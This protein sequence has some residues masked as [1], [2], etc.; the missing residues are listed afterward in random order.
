M[1]SEIVLLTGTFAFLL[2]TTYIWPE[3]VN[4]TQPRRSS[5]TAALQC[6]GIAV[7]LTA[8]LLFVWS[9]CSLGRSWSPIVEA[10]AQ[11][12]LVT[13]GLYRFARHPMYTSFLLYAVAA[14]EH[15]APC[16][17]LFLLVCVFTP[18][19]AGCVPA[20]CSLN[21]LTAA[22]II[23]ISV[24]ASSRFREEE[25]LMM[26]LYGEQYAAYLREGPGLFAPRGLCGGCE[27]C[28]YA[29]NPL[30]AEAAAPL[31]T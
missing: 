23:V 1:R 17:R 10:D 7:S 18:D 5:L 29:R 9:H 21:L 3:V 8:T 22:S 28:C 27:A 26:K 12:E 19:G 14:G 11:H 31:L 24:W 4:Y 20:L 13:S 25:A 6:L 2:Y 16:T 15:A 30:N